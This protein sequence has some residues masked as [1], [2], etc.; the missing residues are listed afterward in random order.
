MRYGLR[1]GPMGMRRYDLRVDEFPVQHER[2][3]YGMMR[4]DDDGRDVRSSRSV[5]GTVATMGGDTGELG[6]R[7]G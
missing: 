4:D 3:R 1:Y 6:D 2:G 5:D 7:S